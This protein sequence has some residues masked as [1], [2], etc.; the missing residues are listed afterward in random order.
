M[1]EIGP[2]SYQ[3]PHRTDVLHIIESSYYA[4][5]IDPQTLEPIKSGETGELILSTLGREGSPLLRY[6]TGDLVK[7]VAEPIEAMGRYDLAL[8]GG[9]LGRCD[10]MVVVRSVN[11]YPGAIEDA[12]RQHTDVAEYR[13][14]VRTQRAMTELKLLIEPVADCANTAELVNDLEEDL[15]TSLNLRIPVELVDP[16]ALPRFEM[17]AKRWMRVEDKA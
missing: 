3:N 10:D 6:R 14:E 9:I 2:V 13:V 1:T 12:V 8:E 11:V 4:E 16:G 15:R 5:V 7:P 17:K